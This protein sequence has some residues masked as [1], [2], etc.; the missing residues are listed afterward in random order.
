MT[1]A[2]T[3]M[4]NPFDEAFLADPYAHHD[5]LRDAGPVVWL[6]SIGVYGMARYAEVQ[7][8]LKD[9]GSFC[10][11]RGV[12]LSDFAKEEPW[13]PPSLLLEVDP[14]VHEKTR[15]IVA[16]TITVATLNALRPT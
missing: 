8:T 16:R 5:A 10:S 1:G 14:P 7:A 12:G 6:D 3:L 9:H 15:E 4:T 2:P 13:R 11:A